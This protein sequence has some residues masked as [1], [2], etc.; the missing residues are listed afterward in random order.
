MKKK[1]PKNLVPKVTPKG[2]PNLDRLAER[3]KEVDLWEA[4]KYL[5][6]KDKAERRLAFVQR[7][8]PIFI[9]FLTSI[10]FFNPAQTPASSTPQLDNRQ[11][12]W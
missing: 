11:K 2:L 10:N 1:S 6:E 12:F 8:R 7:L 5:T 3:L 9:V 4:G